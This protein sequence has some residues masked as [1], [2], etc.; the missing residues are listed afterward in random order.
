MVSNS[1]LDH[2]LD[3]YLDDLQNGRACSRK[4]LLA[5]H[6]DLADELAEYLDGIEMVSGL[7]VGSDLIPQ[8]LG[9]FEI[10]RPIGR[11][12]M[13]VVYLANQISLKRPVA[14]KVLRYSV[15][16][17]QATAR[18]E[19]EAEL[20]ATLQHPNIVPIYATGKHDNHHFLAMQLIDGPSLSQWSA[21]EDADRDPITI[22]KWG[23]EVA[24]ALAHAHQRDV[25]HR[26]VKP[27]NL[28]QD[29]EQ[30]I[31]L[32][33]FGLARRFDDLRMSMTGAMLGTPNYMSPEQASPSRHP[34]DHRT[35]VYS[36]GA[37]LFELLTGRCVFLAETPHA[38]LA[39]VLAEEA[40]PL[41]EL[42]PDASRDL[43]TILMKCLEK[44]PRDRYQTAELLADDLEA[45]AEGRSIKAR[46][47]SIIEQA[48]RWKRHNKKA[49]SWALTAATTAVVALVASV[50]LWFG[51][52]NSQL[53]ELKIQSNEGP[54]VGRLIDAKG[55]PTPVFTI[56]TEQPMPIRDGRYTLQ[57]WASGKW[58]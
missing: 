37:T 27:S 55:E 14:L 21:A 54:I 25:I 3:R 53:G 58:A 10:I 20:V 17:K 44:E 15:T 45:F 18:F 31:W 38:V 40:P 47:P 52:T 33:D 46:R 4:E 16:G 23:A 30:K 42:L 50:A 1:K 32:T 36:L 6:P 41:R 5:Q 22:A 28:L 26:D 57:T 8:R 51:W 7:G 13:G 2:I 19:R 48:V 34:I 56:P 11:G 35:D 29:E 43:E 39:Q 49:V 24:R 9:D 12:A